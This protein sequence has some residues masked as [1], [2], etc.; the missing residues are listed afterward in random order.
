MSR[1][2]RLT[3]PRR[4]LSLGGLLLLNLWAGLLLFAAFS[5]AI[6]PILILRSFL[7]SF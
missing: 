3:G 6:K 1:I 7:P 5:G 2:R 4:E